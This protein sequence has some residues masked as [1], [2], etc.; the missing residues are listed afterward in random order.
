MGILRRFSIVLVLLLWTGGR[1]P[2]QAAS[3]SE[4]QIKAVF[5]FNFA[6]FVEWPAKAFPQEQSP[7]IIGILGED[8]F[9]SFLDDTVRGEKAQNRPLIIQRF[10][11]VEE[12][13]SCH[14]LF[15]AQSEKDRLGTILPSLEGRSILTVSDADAFTARGGMVRFFTVQNKIRLRINLETA[16]A[17]KLTISSKLLHIAEMAGAGREA[18]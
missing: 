4:Y 14:V 9:G 5:L 17:A 7:L 11:R 13:K 18:R 15:I 12:I 2:S 3:P 8:P 10:R 1:W 6:Q 16:K